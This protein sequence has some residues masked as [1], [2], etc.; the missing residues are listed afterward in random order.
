MMTIGTTRI[1]DGLIINPPTISA[2]L[3][4]VST[5]TI[6]AKTIALIDMEQVDS[7][8]LLVKAR[9]GKVKLII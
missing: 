5:A 1:K 8:N 7:V 9:K 3:L 4:P 2:I 6:L